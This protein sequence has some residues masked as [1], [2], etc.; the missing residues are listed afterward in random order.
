MSMSSINITSD[1]DKNRLQKREHFEIGLAN[2]AI[3]KLEH[4]QADIWIISDSDKS[5]MY[6]Y[7]GT[8]IID[9][10]MCDADVH[11]LL[12]RL[13]FS[14]ST[15]KNRLI[16][17][18]IRRGVLSAHTKRIPDGLDESYV[19]GARCIIRPRTA[20]IAAILSNHRHKEFDGL[21]AGIFATI[22]EFLNQQNGRIKLT[23]DFGRYAG[24]A[25]ILFRYTPHVLG[26]RCEQG[27]CGGK[28]SYSSTG[29]V[30]SLKTI[31][32]EDQK[33]TPITLIGSAGAL[34][35][36]MVDY[37]TNQGFSNLVVC[38][39]AYDH[40]CTDIFA[41]S[42]L[43]VLPSRAKSFTAPCLQRGGFIIATTVGQELENS[44]WQL[45]P[46]G[47]ILALAHNLAIPQGAT[48]SNLVR[49]LTNQ[50]VLILPGQLLTL[51][52]ALTSRIEWFWRQSNPDRAFDKPL[53]HAIVRDVVS[54]L[55][56]EVQKIAKTAGV[57]LYE[58]MLL[59]AQVGSDLC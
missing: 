16:N 5:A 21:V 12:K 17:E 9:Y 26:I 20:D 15:L 38:D 33:R 11:C 49:A 50:G 34:G 35:S 59:L 18:A 32:I 52:G 1:L 30:A 7:G 45:I 54:L 13:L 55:T 40:S 53:A 27:G 25:D 36:D 39:L 2:A 24:L 43:P 8:R 57:T 3:F 22:G 28:S 4:S 14:E 46:S 31:G 37:F 10:E 51:G 23:P 44:P 19:S 41:P 6:A 56:I 47:S 48:G 42:Y 58:A 29:I